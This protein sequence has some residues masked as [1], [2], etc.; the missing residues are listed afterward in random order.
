MPSQVYEHIA[1]ELKFVSYKRQNMLQANLILALEI[2]VLLYI[3]FKNVL[4]TYA[5]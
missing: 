1:F 4:Q 5:C 2:G 3:N